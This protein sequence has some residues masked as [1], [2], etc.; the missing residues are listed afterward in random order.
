MTTS[1]YIG[2]ALLAGGILLNDAS[3]AFAACVLSDIHG[4]TWRFQGFG[5]DG[6][7]ISCN[8]IS[9]S[10][11]G[12]ITS[13][14]KCLVGGNPKFMVQAAIVNPSNVVMNTPATCSF[15]GTLTLS[16][17]GKPAPLKITDG[18]LAKNHASATGVALP[19]KNGKDGALFF[20]L[21]KI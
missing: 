8:N 4:T 3:G 16:A 19:G 9:I 13:S 17:A 20:T 7:K 21:T 10:T 18:A 11:A 15:T 6:T 5:E 2:V 1:K 14:A 12:R